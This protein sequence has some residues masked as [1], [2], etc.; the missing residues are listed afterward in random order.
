[1][2]SGRG[3]QICPLAIHHRR[4]DNMDHSLKGGRVQN[5]YF[6][7]LSF[8]KLA[9]QV[10]KC[11]AGELRRTARAG[12]CVAKMGSSLLPSRVHFFTADQTL[13]FLV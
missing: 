13:G 6:F 3:K 4:N 2:K 9:C 7:F 10:D 11:W 12:S 1:M 5:N 8:Y